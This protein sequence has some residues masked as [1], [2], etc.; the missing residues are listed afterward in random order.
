M[1]SLLTSE[2]VSGTLAAN[3][4]Y[5]QKQV[6]VIAGVELGTGSLARGGTLPRVFKID[7]LSSDLLPHNDQKK[8]TFLLEVCLEKLSSFRMIPAPLPMPYYSEKGLSRSVQQSVFYH[9]SRGL[10]RTRRVRL[11]VCLLR[12]QGLPG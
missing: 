2:I 4:V 11:P 12:V 5:N 10:T 8:P 3:V 7:P 1:T 6:F 9:L